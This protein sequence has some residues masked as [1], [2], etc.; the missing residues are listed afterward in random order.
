MN[1]GEQ[2]IE[3]YPQSVDSVKVDKSSDLHGQGAVEVRVTLVNGKTVEGKF[4]TEARPGF[5][6]VEFSSK[7][8]I[9]ALMISKV[10]AVLRGTAE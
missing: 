9:A 7:K 10:A 3:A 4:T 5:G 8:D 1:I 6:G 2:I